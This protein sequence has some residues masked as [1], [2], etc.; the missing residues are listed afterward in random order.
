MT[1]IVILTS[2]GL[3]VCRFKLGVIGVYLGSFLLFL[4]VLGGFRRR[5]PALIISSTL[6]QFFEA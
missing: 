6:D 3:T 1:V 5:A 4:F 2:V